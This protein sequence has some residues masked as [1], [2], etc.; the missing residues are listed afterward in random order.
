MTPPYIMKTRDRF[1][2]ST[3]RPTYHALIA[4]GSVDVGVVVDP[5]KEVVGIS[6][7]LHQHKTRRSGI[8]SS[9]A[10][11]KACLRR[12]LVVCI[13]KHSFSTAALLW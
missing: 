1:L 6:L 9:T 5:L 12:A 13:R 2:S 10:R 8:S 7:G 3:R 11:A 4:P